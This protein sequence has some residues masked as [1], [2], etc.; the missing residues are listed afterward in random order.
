M[1]LTPPQFVRRA[2]LV[3]AGL[4]AIMTI[5]TT[6]VAYKMWGSPPPYIAEGTEPMILKTATIIAGLIIVTV[7][8][9]V[10][11]NI[12]R[13]SMATPDEVASGVGKE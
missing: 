8:L 1:E 9:Y 6:Y 4:S 2:G 12:Y 10:T 13:W 5:R 7:G 3:V 11:R